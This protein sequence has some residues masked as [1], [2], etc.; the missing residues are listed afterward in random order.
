MIELPA[1]LVTILT[2]LIGAGVTW[3]VVEG[4]KMLGE[5][6]GKDFSA[7]ATTIAAIIS[8]SV[9]SAVLGVLNVLLGQIPAEYAEVARAILGLLVVLFGAFGIH[10]RA[11]VAQANALGLIYPVR[12]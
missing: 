6:V 7:L 8:A 3:L 1:E 4:F 11:K 2:A 12:G 10:R 5:A 9:V